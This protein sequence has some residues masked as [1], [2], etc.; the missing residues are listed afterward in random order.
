MRDRRAA[1]EDHGM[2][3]RRTESVIRFEDEQ[4]SQFVAAVLDRAGQSAL[5]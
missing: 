2:S 3:R 4:S 1:G 5:A